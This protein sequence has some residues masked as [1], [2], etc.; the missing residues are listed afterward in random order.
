M[1]K[2]IQTTQF[3]KDLKKVSKRNK[4]DFEMTFELLEVLQDSSIKG[5][6]VSMRPYKLKGKYKNN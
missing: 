4:G 2:L 5:I 6:P 1:Y 3:R